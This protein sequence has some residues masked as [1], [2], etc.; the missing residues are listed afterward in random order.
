MA[1]PWPP[2]KPDLFDG[3]QPEWRVQQQ[4]TMSWRVWVQHGVFRIGPDGLWWVR[5]SERSAIAKGRREL[6]RY[7]RESEREREYKAATLGGV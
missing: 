5:W 2:P 1:K 6:A 4:G 7:V 3:K